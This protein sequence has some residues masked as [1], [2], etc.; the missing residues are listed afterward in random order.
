[1][2]YFEFANLLLKR[3]IAYTSLVLISIPF[4]LLVG[5]VLDFTKLFR[6]A[7]SGSL[8]VFCANLRNVSTNR[9]WGIAL[10]CL[11]KMLANSQDFSVNRLRTYWFS[12]IEK[13]ELYKNWVADGPSRNQDLFNNTTSSLF[14][15]YAHV[16]IK[17]STSR[18]LFCSYRVALM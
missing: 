5:T 2:S 12:K 18:S 10:C 9:K 13:T 8:L 3:G 16:P 6:K 7:A 15:C 14:W 17:H 11:K 1:M 4:F